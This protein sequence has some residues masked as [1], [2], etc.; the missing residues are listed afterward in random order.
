MANPRALQESSKA[1]A[2]TFVT[3]REIGDR[4]S[5]SRWE[6]VDRIS[7][8]S[9]CHTARELTVSCETGAPRESIHHEA[10]SWTRNPRPCSHPHC[11]RPYR[12]R[13]KRK[14]LSRGIGDRPHNGC[15]RASRVWRLKPRR[16]ASSSTTGRTS[17]PSPG[18]RGTGCSAASRTGS[19]SARRRASYPSCPGTWRHIAR[20]W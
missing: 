12:C 4:C 13:W 8:E 15:P 14:H 2:P 3:A 19:A 6:G 10:G 17:S 18:V 1:C 7:R 16:I 20:T 9:T 5:S 11:R